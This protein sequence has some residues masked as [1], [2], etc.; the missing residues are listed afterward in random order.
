MKRV[1][2][3]FEQIADADNLRL[4]F[5]K[6]SRGKRTRDDQRCFAENLES[7]LAQMREGILDFSY[8]IGN[9]KRFVI[10]EP[11]ERTICAASFPERVLHHAIMN[12]CEPHF[13]RWFIFDCYACRKGKGQIKALKRAQKFASENRWFLKCDFRKYFD[14]ISHS[15][16]IEMLDR[17]FKDDAL[18]EWFRR[19]VDTYEVRE[20]YGLPIGNLI[21]QH[22]ANLYLDKLDRRFSLPYVRYM[23][24]FV[25]WSKDKDEL[26]RVRD[27]VVAF[28]GEVLCL[29][30]KGIPYL[31]CVQ[32]GMDFLGM[33][34]FPN[35]IKLSHKSKA[36]FARKARLYD[37]LVMEGFWSQEDYQMRMN[38]LIAFTQNA[39]AMAWRR[40][41]FRE[42]AKSH[43][44]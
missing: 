19:I 31:N 34:I 16:L 10:F 28:A 43:R 38:S 35:E 2:F 42:E 41:F 26:K 24:D 36:R 4:A 17:R 22:L 21:S 30:L 12:L 14:S 5:W 8:P 15:K 11:K 29:G 25:F 3:L 40:K 6:A 37:K 39:N 44:R 27:E 13:E 33:R 18:V 1:G 32:H 9:Y 23:D 20:G 7:N